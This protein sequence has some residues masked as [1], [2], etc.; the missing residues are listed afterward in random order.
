M[1]P[2]VEARYAIPFAITQ[3]IDPLTALIVCSAA[4]ILVMFPVFLFL[5]YVHER[6]LGRR[7]YSRISSFFIKRVEPKKDHIEKKM[8]VYGFFALTLFVAVPLP[9]TGAYTGMLIAWLLDL[10]R[11]KSMISIGIGA[12]T[13]GI[14]ATVMT[15]GVKAMITGLSILLG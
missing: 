11:K 15:L 2:L 8:D 6:L 9:V 13:A 3:G 14:V 4:N 10:D 7:L 1:L 12:F 5:D